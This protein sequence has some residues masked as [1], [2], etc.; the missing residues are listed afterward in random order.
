[1]IHVCFA[2]I[3]CLVTAECL[4]TKSLLLLLQDTMRNLPICQMSSPDPGLFK[5]A[6]KQ[7]RSLDFFDYIPYPALGLHLHMAAQVATSE[8]NC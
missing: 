3:S 6:L 7:H 2:S 5:A 8:E 1:M 4:Q